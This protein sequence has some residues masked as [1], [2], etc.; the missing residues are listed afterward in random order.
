MAGMTEERPPTPGE[1]RL[2]HPPSDRYRAAEDAAAARTSV[3]RPVSANRGV[4]FAAVAMVVG[5]VA[6]VVVAGVLTFT[7]ALLVLAGLIGWSISATFWYGAGVAVARP[8]RLLVPVVFAIGAVV[9]GQIGLW[10]YAQTEG[11]VLPLIDYLGEVFGWLVPL[12]LVIAPLGAAL[13]AR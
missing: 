1:R 12:Q 11:G 2:A 4:A 5:A 6:I 8:T 9:L 10:L 7:G 3:V 13:T